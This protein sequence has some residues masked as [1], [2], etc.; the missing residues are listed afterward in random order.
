MVLSLLESY[1]VVD[2]GGF[3]GF[4]GNPLLKFIYSNRAVRL[5]CSNYSSFIGNARKTAER[6]V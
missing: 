6:G 2:P 3:Q 5:R 4:H 1:P